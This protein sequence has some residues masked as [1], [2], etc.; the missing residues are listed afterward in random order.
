MV[1]TAF[2]AASAIYCEI[3]DKPADEFVLLPQRHPRTFGGFS[4]INV[5]SSRRDKYAPPA[6]RPFDAPQTSKRRRAL[7]RCNAVAA[8]NQK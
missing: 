5:H 8:G 7:Q 6:W 3:D 2:S 1:P 4:S